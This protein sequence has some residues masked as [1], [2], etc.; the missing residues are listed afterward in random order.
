MKNR[1]LLALAIAPLF[2]LG[3]AACDVD[4]TKEGDMPDVDVQ[5]G[6]VPEY[7][8]QPADVD[9]GTDTT[10]VVTPDVDVSQPDANGTDATD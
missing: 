10:Q 2:A 8:V 1:K 3:V 6:E 7:D 4:Q 5:G 9:V